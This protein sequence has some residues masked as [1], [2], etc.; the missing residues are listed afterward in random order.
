MADKLLLNF[1]AKYLALIYDFIF[2]ITELLWRRFLQKKT[3]RLLG[4]NLFSQW[5]TNDL[6][7]K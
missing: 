5:Y 6:L 4:S 2:K 3:P 7:V 1:G